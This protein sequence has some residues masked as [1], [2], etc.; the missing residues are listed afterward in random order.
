[1][2]GSLLILDE[3]HHA[4]PASGAKYA[5]D[6]C[7]TKAVREIAGRFEHRLFLSATRH[8]E[9]VR[10][11]L[12]PGMKQAKKAAKKAARKQPIN[13]PKRDDELI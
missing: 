13:R 6:S 8:A 11:G 1:K 5:I 10:L 2:P 3:A 9:A 4:A 12:A 7:I